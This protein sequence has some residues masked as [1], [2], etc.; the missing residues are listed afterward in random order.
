MQPQRVGRI[1]AVASFSA[2]SPGHE[3][4]GLAKLVIHERRRAKP[5]S[6]LGDGAD[7]GHESATLAAETIEASYLVMTLV[8]RSRL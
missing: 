6:A 2:P 3:K 7:V 5:T 8:R 1:A 4:I